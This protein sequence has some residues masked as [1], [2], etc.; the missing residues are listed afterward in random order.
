[1]VG[2]RSQLSFQQPESSSPGPENISNAGG[3]CCSGVQ[4]I[5]T[6]AEQDRGC[7]HKH[8]ASGELGCLEPVGLD[9]KS[10]IQKAICV[11]PSRQH[12]SVCMYTQIGKVPQCV[13]CGHRLPAGYS[14]PIGQ[15]ELG[16]GSHRAEVILQAA[17]KVGSLVNRG[18]CIPACSHCSRSS[19]SLRGLTCFSESWRN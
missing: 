6:G 15:E 17:F 13:I 10:I 12:D 1:M 14:Y 11:S 4:K 2:N 16:T 8:M 3:H 18:V 9:G 5:A 7:D 19:A